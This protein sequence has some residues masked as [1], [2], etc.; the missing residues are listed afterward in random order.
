MTSR[1]AAATSLGHNR[2]GW[3][4]ARKHRGVSRGDGDGDS[5]LPHRR[6][7]PRRRRR[8]F[9]S[10]GHTDM[11]V[12]ERTHVK[13]RD[14]VFAPG[15]GRADEPGEDAE[16]GTSAGTYTHPGCHAIALA[17]DA[18]EAQIE[19]D[20][21]DRSYSF[22]WVGDREKGCMVTRTCW[23]TLIPLVVRYTVKC[24]VDV[25]KGSGQAR[26]FGVDLYPEMG[27]LLWFTK[28]AEEWNES[29]GWRDGISGNEWHW[30]LFW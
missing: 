8:G 29:R 7:P 9:N 4:V 5:V 14:E 13:P 20:G 30:E 26:K 11:K 3:R 16:L 28:E 24:D 15:R 10:S 2:M 18:D 19:I 22:V 23:R 21:R 17:Y 27:D 6:T 12:A 25:E 1:H